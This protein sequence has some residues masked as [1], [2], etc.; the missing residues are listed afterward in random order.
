[1]VANGEAGYEPGHVTL[2]EGWRDRARRAVLLHRQRAMIVFALLIGLGAGAGAVGFR[3]L[4]LGF[5]YVFTGHADPSGLGHVT[6]PLVPQLG[7][8]S[9]VLVPVIGGL[10]YGPLIARWA[11]E[12]R[13]HGVPEVMYSVNRLGGRI[14]PRVA[15]VKS[16]AS[17]ICI[18]AGGSVGREGPIVQIGSALASA[19]GQRVGV[20]TT[21]LRLLVACGAAGAISATFN[22]PIAGSLFGLELILRDYS[23]RS[24]GP[25]VVSSVAASAVGRSVFGNDPFLVVPAVSIGSPAELLLYAGL[26]VVA[27]GVGLS[28]MRILYAMEDLADRIWN[29]PE[30]ARPACGG[31][32]LGLLLLAVPQVYGVGYPVLENAVDGKYVVLALVGLLVAKLAATSLT[33]AIGGSGGIFAPSLFMGAMVGSAYGA[34]AHGLA[35]NLVPM[36]SVFGLVGMGAVFAATA[37]TPLTAGMIVFELTGQAGLIVPLMATILVSSGLAAATTRDTIYTLK[38]RRRGIEIDARANRSMMHATVGEAMRQL[39][40]RLAPSVPVQDVAARMSERGEDTLPVVDENGT[41]VGIVTAS[42]VAQGL[43]DD[44]PAAPVADIARE[45]VALHFD[46]SLDDA[47]RVLAGGEYEG[48][49]VVDRDGGAVVGW[50][51]HR[52]VLRHYHRRSDDQLRPSTPQPRERDRTAS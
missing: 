20:S 32:L 44:Q 15:V 47:I 34:V 40:D 49:P 38:L 31:L 51:T 37:G 21:Q 11:P 27:C 3:Y 52:C 48:L 30:W 6:H 18:G 12:A 17:A 14:R 5:G 7:I 36:A 9:V 46:D 10:L 45:V 29:G 23:T 22:A 43:D 24:L 33:L 4:I 39:P 19:F 25:V 8:Y 35:P 1:M 41:L 42:D 2:D 13:G 50:L 28:F 26:G 16:L